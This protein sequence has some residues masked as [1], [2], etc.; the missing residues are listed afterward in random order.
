MASPPSV[1]HHC[2]RHLVE[3]AFSACHFSCTLAVR[4]GEDL[5]RW[6]LS[7]VNS[8][9][10]L[11]AKSGDT[12]SAQHTWVCVIANDAVTYFDRCEIAAHEKAPFGTSECHIQSLWI[13]QE[14]DTIRS[15]GGQY[16]DIFFLSLIWVDCVHRKIVRRQLRR[17]AAHEK[18]IA[19]S[20]QL[21]DEIEVIEWASI[22]T[23]LI[24]LCNSFLWV[25]YG[26]IIPYVKRFGSA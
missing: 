21:F 20:P 18:K 22:P 3:E 15:R 1:D 10:V 26:V 12:F 8:I 11:A 6:H 25:E 4:C 5:F 14:A 2:R 13:V 16:N 9:R 19:M 23:Y 24:W 7:I 17:F